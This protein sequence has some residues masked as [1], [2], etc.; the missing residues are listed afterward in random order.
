MNRF[1]SHSFRLKLDRCNNCPSGCFDWSQCEDERVCR[2]LYVK[3]TNVQ[4]RPRRRSFMCNV[5]R[6]FTLFHSFC[7]C[8]VLHIWTSPVHS[9][10]HVHTQQ[11]RCTHLLFRACQCLEGGLIPISGRRQRCLDV[12]CQHQSLGAELGFFFP[13]ANQ[14]AVYLVPLMVT[15][16]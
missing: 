16:S 14:P 2:C 4:S 7:F 1:Y 11:T 6:G 5:T 10:S 13:K 8:S 9:P 15:P 12:S 3:V